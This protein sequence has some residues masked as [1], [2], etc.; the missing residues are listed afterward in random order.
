MSEMQVDVEREMAHPA[1]EVW[2]V[3]GNFGDLSW[4]P[5]PERVEIIGDGVG[6]T[7]RIFMP[8]MDPIDE[9]LEAIDHGERVL[10]YTIPRGLPM[11]ID[12]Y[13]ATVR[14]AALANGGSRVSWS[15]LGHPRG[16]DTATAS[17][18]LRD[19][20]AHMLDWLDTHIGAP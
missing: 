15:A 1:Q 8:G 13:R 4:A 2:A 12:D 3:L 7:R 17:A 19:T 6:M 16:V 11:P 14:V 18:I 20:Y 5:G 10:R 9:R